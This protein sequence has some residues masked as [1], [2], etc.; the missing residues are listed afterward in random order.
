MPR[1]HL[2]KYPHARFIEQ[3]RGICPPN[4]FIYRSCQIV[5]DRS[6]F[7]EDPRRPIANARDSRTTNEAANP[8]SASVGQRFAPGFRRKWNNE[9]T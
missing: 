6:A 9:K 8:S 1:R 5:E 7:V 3:R 2:N 4:R